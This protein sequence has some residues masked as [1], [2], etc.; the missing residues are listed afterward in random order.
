MLAGADQPVMARLTDYRV[1][2][3]DCYGTL[4][5][6]ETGI[7]DALQPLIMD[8]DNAGGA[9]AAEVTRAAGVTRAASDNRH[10]GGAGGDALPA[11]VPGARRRPPAL[12]ATAARRA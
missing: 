9:R 11:L 3:F 7:W 2:T 8:N 12:G 1:L 5:D 6:W 10:A 4:I